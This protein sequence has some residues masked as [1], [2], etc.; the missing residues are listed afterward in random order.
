MAMATRYG[1]E[2]VTI[3]LIFGSARPLSELYSES[4]THRPP[5]LAKLISKGLLRFL[6]LMSSLIYLLIPATVVRLE[7]L[8]APAPVCALSLAKSYMQGEGL[9]R[10]LKAATID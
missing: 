9:G 7:G 1:T 6:T 2:Q 3:S 10:N 5:Q 8:T 4:L